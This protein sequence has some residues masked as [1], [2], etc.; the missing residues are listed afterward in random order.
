MGV[1]ESVLSDR[2]G[3]CPICHEATCSLCK[4]CRWCEKHAPDCKFSGVTVGYR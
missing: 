4:R 3:I 1:S 2:S